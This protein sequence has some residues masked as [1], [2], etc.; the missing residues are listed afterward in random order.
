MSKTEAVAL[1]LCLSVLVGGVSSC[2]SGCRAGNIER[3]RLLIEARKEAPSDPVSQSRY[4]EQILAVCGS[5]E[6]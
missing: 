5:I 1:V 3:C 2:V 4:N 6:R